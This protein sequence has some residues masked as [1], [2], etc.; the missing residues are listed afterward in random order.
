M[1]GCGTRGGPSAQQPTLPLEFGS[2]GSLY[3]QPANGL[4]LQA[5]VEQAVEQFG[6]EA[7]HD[8]RVDEL[9]LRDHDPRGIIVE[10]AMM[11]HPVSLAYYRRGEEVFLFTGRHDSGCMAPELGLGNQDLFHRVAASFRF[12]PAA[13]GQ[14]P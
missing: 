5:T 1:T 13:P 10:M 8:A 9:A 12:G 11:H 6:F 7:Q 14:G 2:E 3:V 4:G